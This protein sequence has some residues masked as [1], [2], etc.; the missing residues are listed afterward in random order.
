MKLLV[1][2]LVPSKLAENSLY[3]FN[4]LPRHFDASPGTKLQNIGENARL[5][6]A[7]FEKLAH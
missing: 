3:T 7:Y 5:N 6:A 2:L 4:N 1:L